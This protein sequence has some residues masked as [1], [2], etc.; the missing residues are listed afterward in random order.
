M[1]ISDH[2]SV[3]V[4]ALEFEV[5]VWEQSWAKHEWKCNEKWDGSGSDNIRR[6]HV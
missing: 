3:S 4:S 1:A 6:Q 2:V 5:C